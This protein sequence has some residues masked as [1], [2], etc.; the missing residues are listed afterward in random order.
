MSQ[1]HVSAVSP[2]LDRTAAAIEPP[3]L[4]RQV[5]S[6]FGPVW[7]ALLLVGLVAIAYLPVIHN[8]FIWDDGQ[9]I[10]E[11]P[12]LRTPLGL[13]RIWTDIHAAPTQYYPLTLTT[14]WLEYQAWGLE[15]LG[16]HLTNVA[17]HAISALLLWRLLLRLGIPGA[18]VGATLFALHPMNVES[19]AWVT[20]RKNVLS[21]VCY[22][23]AFRLYW[24][25]D[26]SRQVDGGQVRWG[27]YALSFLLFLCALASKSVTATLPAAILVAL[28][29]KQGRIWLRDVQPLLPFFAAGTAYGLV[30]AWFEHAFLA[31]GAEDLNWTLAERLQIA[32][33]VPWVY[34]AR[35]VWPWP[36]LFIYPRW[37]IDV[38]RPELWAGLAGTLILLG[39]LWLLRRRI[40][41]GPLAATLYFGGT[42]F[43]VLGFLHVYPM[44]YSITAD[45]F[46]YLASIG[47]VMLAG[48]GIARLAANSPRG[49]SAAAGLSILVVVYI[50]IDWTQ[51]PKFKDEDTLYVATLEKNPDCYLCI[52]NLGV[53][54]TEQGRREEAK[55]M[56]RRVIEIAPH[57][58]SGWY[59]LGKVLSNE[60]RFEEAIPNFEQ[61]I[62]CAPRWLGP[63]VALTKA[64]QQ[65]GRHAE[66]LRAAE[67]GIQYDRT[68]TAYANLGR[69][70][71]AAGNDAAGA[72][73]LDQALRLQP[74]HE[75]ALGNRAM[76]DF[77]QG[78]LDRA[79]ALLR[80]LLQL[81]QAN[82]LAP[83]TLGRIKLQQRDYPQA[84]HWFELATDNNPRD[85]FS[86]GKLAVLLASAPDPHL[87]DPERSLTIASELARLTQQR[88]PNALGVLAVALA[89]NGEIASARRTIESAMQLASAAKNEDLGAELRKYQQAFDAGRPY[90]LEP[91][92]RGN[93]ANPRVSNPE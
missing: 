26:A 92:S 61:A 28:W 6:R 30:T 38:F 32:G 47:P 1:P 67:L 49:I 5:R 25:F 60:G 13:W 21:A 66:A 64:Y 35:I 46:A 17:L 44:R 62:R 23:G 45:H 82:A 27:L 37:T 86:Q 91:V 24:E 53:T 56:F 93:G 58:D 43:P 22:L 20:E 36:L 68:A 89:A 80:R 51:L 11:N 15:P 12:M 63:Y 9:Y 57:D 84:L 83:A 76:L 73:A 40:G 42:L 16:Y 8:R 65:L 78:N 7:Q 18:W 79:E 54:L 71:I 74:D 72:E 48:A 88:E 77:R 69:A 39:T 14:L 31:R 33:R 41:R 55:Q 2:A 3:Q 52:V 59:N 75:E 10:T 4:R 85:L 50:A 34:L 19:V 29:W 70:C 90:V 81:H 87:R